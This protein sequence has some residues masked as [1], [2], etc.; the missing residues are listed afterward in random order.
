MFNEDEF[1]EDAVSEFNLF[2]LPPTQT[3]V[4]DAYHDEIR[5]MSQSSSDGP[6]ELRISGQN[7]KDSLDLKNCQ[8]YVKLKVEKADGTDLTA[9]K[10]GSASLFLQSLFLSTEVSSQNKASI[11]CNY[12]PYRAYIP[13]LLYYG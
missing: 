9:E 7:S 11:T 3:S 4:S 10:G 8:L 13:T 2:E 1:K 12:N 5:P 6:F